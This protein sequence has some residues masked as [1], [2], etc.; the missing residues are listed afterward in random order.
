MC[1]LLMAGERE[2]YRLEFRPVSPRS[3]ISIMPTISNSRCD[4]I[5]TLFTDI[6]K[7]LK[8]AQK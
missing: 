2:R 4:I 3:E 1:V 7:Y 6:G 8:N 5:S